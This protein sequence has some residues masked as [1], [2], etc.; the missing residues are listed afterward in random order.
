MLLAALSLVLSG[1]GAA[2]D[3]ASGPRLKWLPYQ[4]A[5]GSH[6]RHAAVN[7]P[8]AGA[9][10][11][12]SANPVRQAAA[13]PFDDPFGDGGFAA[14]APNPL[15]A[16]GPAPVPFPEAPVAPGGAGLDARPMADGLAATAP[17]SP[18]RTEVKARCLAPDELI[19]PINK[20]TNQIE[21]DPNIHPEIKA[22]DEARLRAEDKE[23]KLDQLKRTKREFDADMWCDPPKTA[24]PDRMTQG[25]APTTFTWK[26]SGLCHKPLYFQQA[27]VERYGH[28][29]GPLTQPIVSAGHFFLTVPVLPYEMAL[30]P[31]Y[32]CMYTLGYYRPGSCAPYYLDPIP[33]SVRAALAEAGVWVGGVFL[34]P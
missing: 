28:S 3:P 22:A 1:A 34:I 15:A 26:A 29:T 30:W 31:P 32:E 23:T 17:V 12:V 19:L 10:Y 13:S 25:W 21:I 5:A 9:R 24:F 27:H 2:A 14:R 11:G 16:A 20:L 8:A 7:E 4:P 18:G 33:L 6:V